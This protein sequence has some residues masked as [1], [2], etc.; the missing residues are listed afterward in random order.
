MDLDEEK[1]ILV[2]ELLEQCLL[3]E[4]QRDIGDQALHRDD[5][6]VFVYGLNKNLRL[7]FDILGNH[8]MSLLRPMQ[9]NEAFRA[10]LILLLNE[11][12]GDNNAPFQSLDMDVVH[13]LRKLDA[14]CYREVLGDQKVYNRCLEYYKERL[15]A[16]KWKRNIGAVYG[17]LRFCDVIKPFIVFKYTVIKISLFTVQ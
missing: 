5:F 15:T 3:P 14:Q 1:L 11:Q 9:E 12:C 16:L 4:F 2:T 10:N 6:N 13:F 8:R 17:Y 7:V